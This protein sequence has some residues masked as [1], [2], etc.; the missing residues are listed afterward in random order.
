VLLGYAG[1]DRAWWLAL[2][3]LFVPDL[4]MAGYAR[5][6][7]SGAL[8]YN[9]AHSYPLPAALGALGLAADSSLT[10][11]LA[12]VWFATS[13]LTGCWATASSTTT[14][15]RI[16]TSAGTAASTRRC[17]TPTVHSRLPVPV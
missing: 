2:L 17:R 8:T 10:Q 14:A 3:V 12:L 1:T 9:L 4:F 7:R 11:G 15:S 5:S 16:R 6:N 13:G